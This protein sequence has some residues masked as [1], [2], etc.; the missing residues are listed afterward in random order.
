MHGVLIM[1]LSLSGALL[2]G[3]LSCIQ[4]CRLQL[5]VSSFFAEPNLVQTMAIEL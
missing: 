1:Q 4:Q 5:G 3:L 2:A